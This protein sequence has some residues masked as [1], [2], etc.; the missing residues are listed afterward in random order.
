M[1]SPLAALRILFPLFELLDHLALLRILGRPLGGIHARG[2][3]SLFPLGNLVTCLGVRLVPLALLY[4]AIA[5]YAH[6]LSFPARLSGCIDSLLL[7][8]YP[9]SCDQAA[10]VWCHGSWSAPRSREP[11]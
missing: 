4:V 8:S 3:V 9:L 1:R 6:A 11:P 5:V 2:G 7:K 10:P